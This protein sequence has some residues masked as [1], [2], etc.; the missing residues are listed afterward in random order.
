MGDRFELLVTSDDPCLQFNR[1]GSGEGVCQGER[2][3]GFQLG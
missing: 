3:L 1:R 2:M